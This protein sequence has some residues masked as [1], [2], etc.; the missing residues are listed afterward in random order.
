[1]GLAL[2]LGFGL[3]GGGNGSGGGVGGSA[4]GG[5]RGGVR[6]KDVPVVAFILAQ[7]LIGP[8]QPG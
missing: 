2:C 1:M 4:L 8:V 7:R 6:R 5:G 3:G